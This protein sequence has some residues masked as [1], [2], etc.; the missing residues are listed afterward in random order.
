MS[1]PSEGRSRTSAVP[2]NVELP[3]VGVVIP[4]H[5][6]ETCVETAI[7]SAVTQDYPNKLVCVL[8][9]GSSDKSYDVVDGLLQQ[10]DYEGRDKIRSG[11][12]NDVPVF[13]MKHDKPTGPSKARNDIIKHLIEANVHLLAILDADDQYLPEKISR[14]VAKLLPDPTFI[15]IVYTDTI[16]RNVEASTLTYEAREPF[17]R[18]RLERENIISN[19]PLIN[20]LALLKVGLYDEELRTCEDW[21]L[22]LRITEHFVAIHIPEPLQIYTVTGDNATFSVSKE[23]W[24]KNWAK[25]QEKLRLRHATR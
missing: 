11:L 19:A 9:D 2:E 13:L 24:N 15:G 5:N 25:V 6:N 21:D 17:D 1:V 18:M 3:L 12:V 16:I 14:S 23:M 7:Q 8:D 22:W 10:T 4:C 20:K